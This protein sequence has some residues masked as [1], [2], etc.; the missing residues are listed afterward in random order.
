MCIYMQFTFKLSNIGISVY[1]YFMDF[2]KLL[3]EVLFLIYHFNEV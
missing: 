1:D 2:F 3:T